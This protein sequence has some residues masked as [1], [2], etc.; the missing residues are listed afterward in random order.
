M[1]LET[2]IDV[3]ASLATFAELGGYTQEH[4]GLKM[5]KTVDDM[6]RYRMVIN[7]TRPEVV[8]E[9]GTR[10]GGFA[11][12]M[13]DVFNVDVV[14]VDISPP[15]SLGDR[16]RC[17][18]LRGSSIDPGVIAEVERLVGGRRCMVTLD[19]DHHAPHVLLEIASYAPMVTPGCYLV[20]EDGLADLCGNKEARR[21][22]R[23]IP[24]C[25]GPMRAII[26]AGLP[27]D[28]RWARDRF[29]EDLTPVSHSPAGWWRREAVRP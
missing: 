13:S 8:V 24:L 12:W 11:A 4:A 29:I 18:V 1:P 9:T 16:P 28:P 25:G 6:A 26:S 23:D 14:T 10:W 27:N 2:L 19:S 5:W 22:G 3:S 17:T 20:V 7:E 21:F 15:E